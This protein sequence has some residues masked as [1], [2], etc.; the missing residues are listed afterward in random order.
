MRRNFAEFCREH[1]GSEASALSAAEYAQQWLDR[2]KVETSLAT[3]RR[4]QNGID[5]WLKF[6]GP[7]AG[8][9]LEEITQRQVFAF[10]DARAKASAAN[11]ANMELKI[12]KMMFR[13]ARREGYLFEDPAEGIKSVKNRSDFARRPFSID[14]LRA[15]LAVADEEWQILVKFGLYS[16][17]RIGDLALLTWSQI[18]LERDEIRLTSRKTGKQLL[19]PIAAPLR[20]HLL[21]LSAGD[22]PRA[23][24][25]PRAYETVSTQFGRVSTLSNQFSDL[26]VACGL[27]GPQ[28]HQS[29]DI[30][31]SPDK[32]KGADLSFH[33]LRH[34]AVSLLKDAGVPDAVVMALVGHYSAAMSHRYTHVGKEALARAAK[35]LPAIFSAMKAR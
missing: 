19:I 34:T 28:P 32:R 20:E 33:S 11:T 4:Y 9:G 14:E 15:V 25:H 6:L 35:T 7:D 13:S 31:L 5:K 23:P 1:F 2:R 10:R 3:H 17:Q 27:R 26:L 16:A 30:G 29:R 22:N 12:I 18:D 24:V 8:R 21:A